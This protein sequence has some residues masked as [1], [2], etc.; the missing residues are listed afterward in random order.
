MICGVH[1]R[2]SPDTPDCSELL[3]WWH[4]YQVQSLNEYSDDIRNGL[5]QNL[6]TVRR[7]MELSCLTPAEAGKHC[8]GQHLTELEKIYDQLEQLSSHLYSPYLEDSLPLALEHALQ[9]WHSQLPLHC[10]WSSQWE[11]EPIEQNRLLISFTQSLLTQL[12]QATPQPHR[13]DIVLTQ[14]SHAKQL[15]YHVTYEARPVPALLQALSTQLAPFLKTFQIFTG[16]N[17]E[18]RLHP[19]EFAWVLNWGS[20]SPAP[21]APSHAAGET[22]LPGENVGT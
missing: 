17:Y 8:C 4:R 3:R 2:L 11:V 13:C 14:T 9:P 7:Q 10:Q 22:H 20:S 18:Q 21:A 16:G 12:T 15:R 19:Q 6:F 1:R 5:L